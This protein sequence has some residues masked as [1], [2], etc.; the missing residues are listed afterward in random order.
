MRK[1]ICILMLLLF[2]VGITN[3]QSSQ[4]QRVL[5]EIKSA[6]TE[7]CKEMNKQLPIEVDELTTFRN[8]IFC[9]WTFI[10][11]YNLHIDINEWTDQEKKLFKFNARKLLINNTRK[12]LFANAEISVIGAKKLL[13]MTGMK[14]R[15]NDYDDNGAFVFSIVVGYNE[16]FGQNIRRR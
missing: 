11:N 13:R 5:N 6:F 3:A 4:T 1:I 14:Y 10:C 8:I 7:G 12:M 15:Y 2:S 16:L 9:D